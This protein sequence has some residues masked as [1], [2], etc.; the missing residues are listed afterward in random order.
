MV[1][2][3]L[4]IDFNVCFGCS[5]E[6]SRRD[7]SFEYPQHTFSLRNRKIQIYFP[8]LIYSQ[9]HNRSINFDRKI[10]NIFLSI[11]FNTCLGC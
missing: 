1:N 10:V 2:I 3:F 6:P 7:G 11:H 4:S 9:A 5:K 8:S